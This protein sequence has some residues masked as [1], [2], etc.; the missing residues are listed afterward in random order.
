MISTYEFLA[1]WLRAR[2]GTPSVAPARRVRPP[3]GPHRRRLH[4]RHQRSSARRPRA[5]FEQHRT[6]PSAGA[7][8]SA[9]ADISSSTERDGLGPSLFRVCASAGA[10]LAAEVGAHAAHEHPV[11]VAVVQ[12]PPLP[13]GPRGSCAR[14]PVAR[15]QHEVDVVAVEHALRPSGGPASSVERVRR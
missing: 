8:L 12:R 3:R 4:R 10:E 2:F 1:T 13:G 14:A 9:D 6:P 11:L 7:D 15:P 5:S